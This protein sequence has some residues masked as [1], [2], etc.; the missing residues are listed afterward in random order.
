MN[1][2]KKR[3][4]KEFIVLLI[5]AGL[6]C[7]GVFEGLKALENKMI[8]NFLETNDYAY[9]QNEKYLEKFESYV[10]QNKISAEDEDGINEFI[11]KHRLSYIVMGVYRNGKVTSASIYDGYAETEDMFSEI[12]DGEAVKIIEFSDGK[13]SV[14]LYGFFG[15]EFYTY[16][17]ISQIAFCFVL[18][19]AICMWFIQKKIKYILCLEQDIK[20]LET[21]GLDHEIKI[22][23]NDELSS[24]ADGLNNMRKSLAEN[25]RKQEQASRANHDL[26]VSVAHDLRTPLTAL[27]LY[28][29]LIKRGNFSKEDEEKYFDLARAKA[30]QIKVLTDSLF[31]R[32]LVSKTGEEK[33]LEPAA[34]IKLVFEDILSDFVA[35]LSSQGF[36][37]SCGIEWPPK[38]VC[39]ITEYISRIFDNISS[40]IIK[41]ASKAQPI[42]LCLGLA[43]DE[44]KLVLS[45][46][47]T[48]HQICPES[49]E[50]FG[51]GIENIKAMTAKMSAGCKISQQSGIY[52][53]TLEFELC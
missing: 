2:P 4:K 11:D 49:T 18:F 30:N 50:S 52:T 20:V 19:I 15:T 25:I 32:F 53:V 31:E 17:T 23:G 35:Y 47:N 10:K 43:E 29:D 14:H 16:A 40:N 7:I 22:R 5:V 21:G 39:V 24:L 51:I 3:L 6:I 9:R 46:S 44:K 27:L 34:E 28:L 42:S 48:V 37:V 1:K 12:Y 41:Y 38:K 33:Q 26:V 8:D 13:A 36:E 45:V